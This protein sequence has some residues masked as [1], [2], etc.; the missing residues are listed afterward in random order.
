MN[1]MLFGVYVFHMF[2]YSKLYN[3]NTLFMVSVL[4]YIN[5]VRFLKEDGE[6]LGRERDWGGVRWY[7]DKR[8]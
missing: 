3:M 6:T 8:Q 7:L 2:N 1:F 5:V 4:L